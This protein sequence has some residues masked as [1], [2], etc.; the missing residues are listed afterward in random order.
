MATCSIAAPERGSKTSAKR[1]VAPQEAIHMTLGQDN[2]ESPL[3]RKVSLPGEM[4]LGKQG[5]EQPGPSKPTP[6]SKFQREQPLS[7]EDPHLSRD[8]QSVQPETDTPRVWP[9]VSQSSAST[10]I[11]PPAPKGDLRETAGRHQRGCGTIPAS[12]DLDP[13]APPSKISAVSLEAAYPPHKGG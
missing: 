9:R 6:K 12:K 1:T 7:K 4:K 5:E 3:S 10:V 2:S 13:A 11:A 8:H